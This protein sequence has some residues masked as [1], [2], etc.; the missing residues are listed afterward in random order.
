[1]GDIGDYWKDVKPAWR[2][3]RKREADAC[4]DRATEDLELSRNALIPLGVC[5]QRL[6]EGVQYNFIGPNR[7]WIISFY[8]RNGRILHAKPGGPRIEPRGLETPSL[9]D[10]ANMIADAMRSTAT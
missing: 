9:F 3:E 1:M 6:N 10:V 5:V 8:P 2:A 4:Y 7:A